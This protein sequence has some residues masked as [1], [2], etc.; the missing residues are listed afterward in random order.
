MT[1]HVGPSVWEMFTLSMASW[2]A[3]L[4]LG[5]ALLGL[6]RLLRTVAGLGRAG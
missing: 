5:F 4:S 2:N 6:G 1:G 3:I